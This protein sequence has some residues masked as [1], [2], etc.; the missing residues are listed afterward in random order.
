GAAATEPASATVSVTSAWTARSASGPCI[1][2]RQA[3][4]NRSSENMT[5]PNVG[6]PLRR[7]RRGRGRAEDLLFLDVSAFMD[8]Y[9]GVGVNAFHVVDRSVGPMHHDRID[10]LRPCEPERQR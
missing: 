2:V 4:M 8:H 5:E 9:L 7:G 1:A 3:S 10:L 6:L